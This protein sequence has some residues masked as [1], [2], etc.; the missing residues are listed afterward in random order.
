M[1]GDWIKVE[2]TMPDKPEIFQMAERLQIDPDAV[3]GKLLR[4]WIWADQQTVDGNAPSVT[5]ALLDRV[6]G[7]TGFT[8]ALMECGWLLKEGDGYAFPNFDRH[9]GKTAKKRAQTHKRVQAHRSDC[10]ANR[11]APSVTKALPE[12]RREEI[13]THTHPGMPEELATD[14]DRWMRFRESVDGR[15]MD[16]IQADAVLMDL[17]RRGVEKAKRDI[18]FSIQK[19]ARTILDSDNDFTK[20]QAASGSKKMKSVAELLGKEAS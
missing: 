15:R 7:V 8:E 2:T 19:G 14:W 3:A 18:D 16:P 11:N 20:R 13:N 10:N 6:T 5:K 12:K 1:A 4:V 9:N 17:G